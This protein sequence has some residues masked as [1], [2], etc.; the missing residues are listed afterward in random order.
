M[1]RR[2]GSF[3]FNLIC[4]VMEIVITPFVQL[5]K[6][7][8]GSLLYPFEIFW[9]WLTVV[10]SPLFKVKK[11]LKKGKKSVK[12]KISKVRNS[13]KESTTVTM[14]ARQ[15][16]HKA[17]KMAKDS[18]GGR[19]PHQEA[20]A[21]S[22]KDYRSDM[23]RIIETFIKNMVDIF[24]I[25][26][27]KSLILS[28]KATVHRRIT[29][30]KFILRW[31]YS[32]FRV[33]QSYQFVLMLLDLGAVDSV[34]MVALFG[35]AVVLMTAASVIGGLPGIFINAV[36]LLL[37]SGYILSLCSMLGSNLNDLFN[38]RLS[39]PLLIEQT[40]IEVMGIPKEHQANRY[41][42]V[43]GH[44]WNNTKKKELVKYK[45]TF[46]VD[47]VYDTIW[48]TFIATFAGLYA[49]P[50]GASISA[51][52]YGPGKVRSWNRRFERLCAKY[53]IEPLATVDTLT[54]KEICVLGYFSKMSTNV[55]L[56]TWFG[57]AVAPV[58][59][60]AYLCLKQLKKEKEKELQL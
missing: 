54:T 17:K 48:D 55:P 6:R 34:A 44:T 13:V 8:L 59:V 18:L 3:I 1:L 42:F 47:F 58:V 56:L 32:C 25:D 50:V 39:I 24:V 16:R 41:H 4:T 7:L 27:V 51:L 33:F 60:T 9:F 5:L 52:V 30:I 36:I 31:A 10:F 15:R 38:D 26:E 2:M 29:Q 20:G 12:R 14:N 46:I 37:G 57:K 23:V 22:F 21:Y 35:L 28:F 43:M 19:E 49:F 40:F 11:Q 45:M 53:G